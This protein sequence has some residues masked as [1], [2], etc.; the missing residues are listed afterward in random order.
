MNHKRKTQKTLPKVSATKYSHVKS[1]LNTGKTMRDVEILSDNKV[2]SIRNEIFK[3]MSAKKLSSLLVE[4]TLY[5]LSSMPDIE[6]VSDSMK[7]SDLLSIN[8]DAQPKVKKPSS[9]FILLD[10]RDEAAYE[11]CHISQCQLKS[12]SLIL[13][14][15]ESG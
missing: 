6:N 3:R 1:K 14:V 4:N 11:K 2:A 10:L 15:V 13:D 12:S 9:D 8:E 5:N 7:N